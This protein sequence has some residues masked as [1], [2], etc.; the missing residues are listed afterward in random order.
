MKDV[1]IFRDEKRPVRFKRY[2]QNG[3]V[4]FL[5]QLGVAYFLLSSH[6]R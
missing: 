6:G 2:I 4:A 1:A 5:D 3:R